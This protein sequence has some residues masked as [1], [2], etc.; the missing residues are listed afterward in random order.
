MGNKISKVPKT[1]AKEINLKK[2]TEN[3]KDIVQNMRGLNIS[4][5]VLDENVPKHTNIRQKLNKQFR[6][7]PLE[8]NTITTEEL[9]KALRENGETR[10]SY[11]IRKHLYFIQ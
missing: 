3:M 8:P 10:L 9:I 6:E 4:S 2:E 1:V 7:N 5:S 11:D